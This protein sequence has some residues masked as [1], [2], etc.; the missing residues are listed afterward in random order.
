M[1]FGIDYLYHEWTGKPVAVVTYGG[2][3]GGKS[4]AQLRQVLDGLHLHVVSE[5][6]AI[7]LPGDHISGP[8]RAQREGSWTDT[9]LS[10]YDGG[11][12]KVSVAL[13]A[14]LQTP[15]E[16]PRECPILFD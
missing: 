8:K 2:N 13:L 10:A 14:L 16:L 12:E 3:G 15:A 6:L 4:G 11:A 9:F 5:E 1:K 7:T